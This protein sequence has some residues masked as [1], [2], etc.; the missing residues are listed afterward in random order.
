MLFQMADFFSDFTVKIQYLFCSI[1][2]EQ[3]GQF[4][5]MWA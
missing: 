5:K 1:F 4:V 3:I 2:I